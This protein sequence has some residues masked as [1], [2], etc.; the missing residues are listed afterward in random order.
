AQ[1]EAELVT[2]NRHA[3]LSKNKTHQDR[4]DRRHG[5]TAPQ[6]DESAER[7]QLNPQK[8][9][10]TKVQREVGNEWRKE[11]HQDDGKSRTNEGR[12]EGRGEGLSS[13]AFPGHGI[14]V[15]RRGHGP[16]LT[17]DIKEN[18]RNRPTKQRPPV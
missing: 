9:R 4:G 13:H 11:G 16:R 5:R 2:R 3:D 15:K 6:A 7:Q 17:G 14:A 10:W 18:R 1:G 12:R 8:L